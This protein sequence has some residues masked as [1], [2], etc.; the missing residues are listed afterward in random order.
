MVKSTALS[1]SDQPECSAP[2]SAPLG[3]G[4]CVKT[5]HEAHCLA[6]VE[7]RTGD[8]LGEIEVLVSGK[9]PV[10]GLYPSSVRPLA[11]DDCQCGVWNNQCRSVWCG[12]C[13]PC[14]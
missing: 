10:E 4:D 5:C 6:L 8:S 9:D 13:Q 14:G 1:V 3:V 12:Q 11:Q 2:E 7:E